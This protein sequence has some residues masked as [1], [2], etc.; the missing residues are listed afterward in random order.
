MATL[1]KREIKTAMLLGPRSFT[2]V[3]AARGLAGGGGDGA[4]TGCGGV[5]EPAVL[6]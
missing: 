5:I 2:P 4:L 1:T 3:R 6:L